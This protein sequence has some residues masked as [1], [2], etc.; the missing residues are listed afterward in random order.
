[1]MYAEHVLRATVD[2]SSLAALS[3]RPF[4]G[5]G[6]AFTKCIVPD[7]PYT[8]VSKWF[9]RNPR[10]VDELG[11][12]IREGGTPKRLRYVRRMDNNMNTVMGEADANMD[13]GNDQENIAEV[14]VNYLI[15]EVVT[16]ANLGELGADTMESRMEELRK[17]HAEKIRKY[18]AR[19][20]DLENQVATLTMVENGSSRST[21]IAPILQTLETERDAT[22]Q[23]AKIV[24]SQALEVCMRNEVMRE[25]MEAL[26]NEVVDMQQ[27][28]QVVNE[29]VVNHLD[30]IGGLEE[31]NAR[32]KKFLGDAIEERKNMRTCTLFAMAKTRQFQAEF[33]S[34]QKE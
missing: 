18:K 23:E 10:L 26:Q 15:N 25:K 20:L 32:L 5:I 34:I 29:V 1:M 7:I 8:T 6:P 19:I 9:R 13:D 11:T 24:K 4:G 28:L 16:E 33:E 21:L 3:K 17:Q 12:P 14:E 30:K 22:L 31:Q 27:Q 2:C